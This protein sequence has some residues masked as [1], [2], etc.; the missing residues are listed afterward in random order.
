MSRVSGVCPACGEQ[1][2]ADQPACGEM[3]R[4]C[5]ERLIAAIRIRSAR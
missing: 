1:L 3:H 2:T 5:V 4:A